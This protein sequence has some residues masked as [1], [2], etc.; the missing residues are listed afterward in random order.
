[1]I[2]NGLTCCKRDCT[3]HHGKA[4]ASIQM[5]LP[6]MRLVRDQ[7]RDF[8]SS[9]I[10]SHCNELDGGCHQAADAVRTAQHLPCW[11]REYDWL[12]TAI[13]NEM[14]GLAGSMTNGA[15]PIPA[16]TASPIRSLLNLTTTIDSLAFGPDSQV[17]P[18]ALQDYVVPWLALC[19][20]H[21]ILW[22]HVS[23]ILCLL[24]LSSSCG[25]HHLPRTTSQW[26]LTF[27]PWRSETHSANTRE[28]L[29]A[30]AL[31][32]DS[33]TLYGLFDNAS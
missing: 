6:P 26:L 21:A 9:K 17:R 28:P 30:A 7:L 27:H 10:H 13:L 1:M 22:C 15:V 14:R 29:Q 2:S 12:R 18:H 11:V 16:A 4:A 25:T 31:P 32:V 20:Y 23:H 33:S 5:M 19:W 3:G 8:W 24:R